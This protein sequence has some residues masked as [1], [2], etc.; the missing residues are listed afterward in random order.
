VNW[1]VSWLIQSLAVWLTAA[2]L[3]GF[4]L[5]GGVFAAVRVAAL[6]GVLQ[7]LLGGLI[8]FGI[9]VGTLGIG[10]L[11]AFLTRWLVSAILLK[12]VDAL[13]SSLTIVSFGRAFLA[14]LLMSAIGTAGEAL[15]LH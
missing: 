11:L 13:S 12:L 14:A 1:L 4:E 6:F 9:G 5:R 15:L 10:F 7:F 8:Y 2:V 3:P